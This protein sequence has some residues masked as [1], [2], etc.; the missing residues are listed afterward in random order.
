MD[1]T[2]VPPNRWTMPL[3]KIGDKRYYLGIFFKVNVCCCYFF[4]LY[5][6]HY[7]IFFIEEPYEVYDVIIIMFSLVFKL[8][9]ITY[10]DSWSVLTMFFFDSLHV[11]LTENIL[12]NYGC[13]I[14][15]H[16]RTGL[17]L[18]SIVDIMECILQ[19]F[20]GNF[21]VSSVLFI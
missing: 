15:V 19:V 2:H 17:E 20:R 14:G 21:S 9:I 16:R 7:R 18:H 3:T 8:K 12:N 1:D 13:F 10:L 6:I 4:L 11:P 5:I